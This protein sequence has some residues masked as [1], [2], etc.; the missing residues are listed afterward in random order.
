MILLLSSLSSSSSPNI[1]TCGATFQ[2]FWL[3]SGPIHP[4]A[5]MQI[6]ANNDSKFAHKIPLPI[7]V[8]IIQF[9]EYVIKGLFIRPLFLIIFKLSVLYT[10]AI[11]LRFHLHTKAHTHLLLK[12]FALF[13]PPSTILAS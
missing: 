3:V 5:V 8:N 4:D 12:S 6:E 13:H 1:I 11:H 10:N 9:S 2:W 7:S